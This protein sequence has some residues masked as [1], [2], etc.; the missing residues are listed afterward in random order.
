[1][2]EKATKLKV[3]DQFQLAGNKRSIMAM[4]LIRVDD[5]LHDAVVKE[6]SS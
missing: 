1:M 3:I 6:I 5:D 2:I 4:S